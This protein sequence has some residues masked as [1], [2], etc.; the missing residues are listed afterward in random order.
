LQSYEPSTAP[1]KGTGVKANMNKKQGPLTPPPTI[2]PE[3]TQQSSPGFESPSRRHASPIASPAE[4]LTSS[5]TEDVPVSF[6]IRKAIQYPPIDDAIRCHQTNPTWHE[7]MLMYDP[8]VLEDL[9][10][11]LNTKGFNTIGEDR[12]I[13]IVEVKDWCHENGICCLWRGGW[14]GNKKAKGE[15]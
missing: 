12:E 11:W 4:S 1:V 9:T 13:N 3:P 5:L 8:I 14:R 7:K 10:L 6:L 2:P 15:E